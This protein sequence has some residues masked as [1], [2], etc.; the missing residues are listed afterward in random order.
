MIKTIMIGWFGNAAHRGVKRISRK[1]EL[2][3]P[4]E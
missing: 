3:N 2:Q 4:K 1:S